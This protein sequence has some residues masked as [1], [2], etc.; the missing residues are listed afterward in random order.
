VKAQNRNLRFG[1]E[2]GS[3]TSEN[4][5]HQFFS[6]IIYNNLNWFGQG[7][8]GYGLAYGLLKLKRLEV[9]QPMAH[10]RGLTRPLK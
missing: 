5:T 7:R 9:I 8:W 3:M 4:E 1:C 2:F 10:N 6:V